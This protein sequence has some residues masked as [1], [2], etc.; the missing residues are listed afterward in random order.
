SP[1]ATGAAMRPRFELIRLHDALTGPVK[2]ALLV[3][4]AAVG[5][6][7]LI[8]CVN[9]ANLLLARTASRQLEIAV[10]V[11]IGAGR[12]RLV[13]QLLTESV[14]LAGVGG[15]AGIA[16]A[17]W[18][19]RLF[20]GLGATLGRADL[21]TTSAFPRLAE[22]GVDAPVLGYA[23]A[24]SIVTGVVFG[25]VPALRHSRLEQGEFLRQGTASPRSRLKDAL[26]V[27]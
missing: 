10:R 6:V 18:G 8:A 5:I 23:L 2:P 22:V 3:L 17:F 4:T 21:S 15:I 19:V 26:V 7:L 1:P 12:A 24:L 14:L 13:R 20:R 25:I 9:V 27:A 16:L 11:A